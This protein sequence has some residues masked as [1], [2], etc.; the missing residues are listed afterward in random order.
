MLYPDNYNHVWMIEE[1][2]FN[3]DHIQYYEAV[4]TLGNGYLG[5][6][7]SLEEK[8]RKSSPSTFI[9]GLFDKA[10]DQVTELANAANWLDIEISIN[11]EK[12]NLE[13]NKIIEHK[14]VLDLQSGVLYRKSL[15]Q[16]NSKQQV[17][18]I[19]RR[20]VSVS[21]VH[22]MG[23]EYNFKI[24]DSQAAKKRL[25]V[26]SGFDGDVTN[27]GVKHFSVAEF[28]DLEDHGL[29]IHQKALYSDHQIV[30]GGRIK[31][32]K[33]QDPLPNRIN[34][35]KKSNHVTAKIITEI[36]TNIR[37]RLEK[38]VV[39]YSSRESKD[40]KTAVIEKINNYR[41]TF[42]N[43]H[44]EE[45]KKVWMA[46]W[47]NSDIEIKGDEF[48]QLA[49]RFSIFHLLQASSGIDNRISIPAKALT[50]FGYKGHV[51]WD[52]EIFMLPY[53]NITN[54][55][56]SQNMLMYRYY[57]L[58]EARKKA[59]QNGYNGALFAW[60]SADTGEE[61]TPK[62]V[63]H[64]KENK[65]IRIWCG[66]N[67]QHINCDVAYAVWNYFITTN[68]I[69]FFLKYGAEIIFE[70]ARFW[71][72]RVEYNTKMDRFEI[73][74]VIGPDEYHENID[75]NYFTN[76]MA[77]W[78]IRK[79]IEIYNSLKKGHRS[80][81]E[82]I[83]KKIKLKE[84]ELAKWEKIADKIFIPFDQKKKL[85]IQFDGFMDLED[86][87]LKEYEDRTEPMDVVIGSERIS[88]SKII[89]QADVLMFFSLFRSQFSKEIKN[90]NWD[91][92]EPLC[93]H[94]SSLSPAVHSLIASDLGLSDKAYKY[95]I[96]A[97]GI[98]LKDKMGNTA[99]GIHAATAGGL[100]QAAIYGFAGIKITEEGLII[101]P[102]LPK[103]WESMKFNLWYKGNRICISIN[104]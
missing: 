63:N 72:S 68:D 23:I 44:F 4:F 65:K 36:E 38:I 33:D 100:L 30:L 25:E 99:N 95:F 61:T 57:T 31:L 50:G 98:D 27:E 28:G 26:Y 2:E 59:K 77:Q 47:E 86:I 16:L 96:Q 39:V 90:V 42:I 101:N 80:N 49:I 11:G 89:K 43:N 9:A 8:V 79:G 12:V 74:T 22:L 104:C 13:K 14:R 3:P 66:D 81:W 56:L 24:I 53:L 73:K 60:E 37:Y 54:P 7:G 78:N 75:N 93:G 32:F 10:P 6:R 87:D 58:E 15:L 92:Y 18:I 88:Q 83:V 19:S 94:G 64:F 1:N 69:D 51:F 45:H 20:F 70:T 84:K 21:D 35:R 29:F 85:F 34:V 62:F 67:E 97:A 82:R 76:A 103:H 91:F 40:P 5:T 48:A 55:L 46:R 17:E 41:K 71:S 52:T 102:K